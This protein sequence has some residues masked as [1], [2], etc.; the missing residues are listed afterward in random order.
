MALMRTR[1]CKKH[2]A[3]HL[4]LTGLPFVSVLKNGR[5]N[6]RGFCLV[7]SDG[8]VVALATGLRRSERGV[9]LCVSQGA[10]SASNMMRRCVLIRARAVVCVAD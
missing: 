8:G 3:L 4:F 5:F 2:G 10:V 9:V 6:G 7:G 1:C